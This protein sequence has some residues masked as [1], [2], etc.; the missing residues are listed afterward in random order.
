M[1]SK[2]GTRRNK[3]K[4]STRSNSKIGSSSND[5][6]SEN[7]RVKKSKKTLGIDCIAAKKKSPLKSV[8]NICNKS[9]LTN[10]SSP[11]RFDGKENDV[12]KTDLDLNLS[13]QETIEVGKRSLWVL[14]QL[15]NVPESTQNQSSKQPESQLPL[16]E[17]KPSPT[18][19]PK[20]R[21]R[22][23]GKNSSKIAA[24]TA[25][26]A[27]SNL[28]MNKKYNSFDQDQKPVLDENLSQK[29]NSKT[30]KE[31]KKRGR[32]RKNPENITKNKI[33]SGRFNV[34]ASNSIK[35]RPTN[36]SKIRSYDITQNLKN[37]TAVLQV[38]KDL[39]F[40]V[41]KSSG[42]LNQVTNNLINIDAL[43]EI[44]P[45]N[46]FISLI[47]EKND[48]L[49]NSKNNIAIKLDVPTIFTHYKPLN[50]VENVNLRLLIAPFPQVD[51]MI[52][53]NMVSYNYRSSNFI[54]HL[55]KP[56]II[57][58]INQINKF[59]RSIGESAVNAA[60]NFDRNSISNSDETERRYFITKYIL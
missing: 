41:A 24:R 5:E 10:P 29:Q 20:R 2:I 1:S 47:E 12:F 52:N 15:E 53:Q 3:A 33:S 60:T 17:D 28:E 19:V 38:I 36:L 30:Y 18:K 57:S 46:A 42:N 23:P 8:D 44:S 14:P 7:K 13:K 21:G 40:R 39:T 51:A 27:L 56:N 59:N 35:G 55:N 22:P 16:T 6:L 25:R 50:W 48:I 49:T 43:K 34:P 54:N 9:K 31:P 37:K 11:S 45:N 58:N 32:K 4:F 26:E